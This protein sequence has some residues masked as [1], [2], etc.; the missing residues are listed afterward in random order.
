MVHVGKPAPCRE[1]NKQLSREIYMLRNWQPVQTLGNNLPTI[2]E[3]HFGSGHS[4]ASQAIRWLQPQL[5]SDW[6]L[7]ETL[8][9][10]HPATSFPNSWPTE[11]MSDN[12]C[13][14]LF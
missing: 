7:S 13:L 10:N 6:M 4:S 2:W 11:S 14:L 8:N 5:T 3:S 9:Q 12:I 1:D